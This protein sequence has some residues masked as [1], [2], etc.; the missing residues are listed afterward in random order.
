MRKISTGWR[1]ALGMATAVATLTGTAGVAVA[2]PVSTATIT[3]DTTHPA[4]RLA[5]DFVG[6]SFEM[7]ELGIGN[8]D[9]AKGN[10]AALFKTL[11]RSNVRISGNTLDRD[12]LWVPQGQEPPNPLPTWVN[13]VVTP[14]DV[15]RLNRFL[16]VTGW[17]TMVGINLGRWD[18]ALGT[19]QAKSMFSILGRK[20]VAAECGNEPDQWV[21][22]AFRPAGYAYPDYK[23]DWEMCAAAVGSKRIA[24]PDTAGT[25]SSWAAS[26]AADEKDRMS[27]LTVHQY[28]AGPDATI[29][30]LMSPT[31]VTSQLNSVAK[32]LAA[33]KANGLPFRIDEANSAYGGGVDGVSNKF[34]SALWGLDYSMQMAQAGVDGINVHGGLGVCNDPI[35]NGKFQRYTP[36]CAANAADEQAKVYKAMPIYYGLWMARQMKSG[37]FLPL[38]LSTDRNVTA[39]AVKGDDGRTRIAV[40]QKDETT[41]APVHLDIAVD[42]RARSAEVLRLTGDTLGGEATAIQ[43]ATVDRQGHLNPRRADQVRVRNG[44][45]GVDVAAGSAVVITL[46]GC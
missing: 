8:L 7:R 15:K 16:S 6:L 19:D 40:I 26:L 41:A 34:A 9:P 12:T 18:Q 39:Y 31:T 45:L 35:W 4:G 1:A 21:G 44:S 3:I 20:L 37:T 33:A 17:N 46:D 24:G 27:M 25:S 5:S 43:G 29:A 14:T 30:T 32:N 28:S 36:I 23:K 11:G 2:D 10:A 22:K 13:D 38:T 42:G